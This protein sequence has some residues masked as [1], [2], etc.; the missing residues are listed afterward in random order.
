M[1][2]S[3]AADG[4]IDANY[5]HQCLVALRE[6]NIRGPIASMLSVESAALTIFGT[7]SMP[8]IQ[9]ANQLAELSGFPVMIKPLGEYPRF[10]YA[11]RVSFSIH[12]SLTVYL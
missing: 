5:D 6:N 2:D 1:Y 11:K 8:V 9:M 12:L 3:G 4:W 10:E 7:I